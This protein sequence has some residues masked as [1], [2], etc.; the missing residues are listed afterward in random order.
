MNRET[1]NAVSPMRSPEMMSVGDTALVVIDVQRK[2]IPL[3]PDH[4]RIVWNIGRLIQ[5]AMALGVP[6]SAT[7]QYPQGLGETIPEVAEALRTAGVGDIPEKL[8]FSCAGCEGLFD[9]WRREGVFRL[10]I[11][12]IE[13]HVCVMQTVLD[14]MSAGFRVAVA[15]DAVGAR[16]AMDHETA[17]RRMESCGA[18]L[19]TCESA[20]CEL[21]ESAGTPRFKKISGLLQQ[22]PPA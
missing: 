5:G 21:C 7:E 22:T 13:T 18:T 1:E 9:G 6:V 14:A 15:V 20:L 17:L 8:S 2:L 16:W 12:G 11:A 3:V 19:T 10:L 4:G